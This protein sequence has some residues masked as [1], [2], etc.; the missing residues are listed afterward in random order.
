MGGCHEESVRR[1]C[2]VWEVVGR[3]EGCVCATPLGVKA[4]CEG[5]DCASPLG[6]K[7]KYTCVSCVWPTHQ[8]EGDERERRQHHQVEDV[9]VRPRHLPTQHKQGIRSRHGVI[10]VSSRRVAA[11]GVRCA[12]ARS[13]RVRVQSWCSR[14]I[15]VARWGASHRLLE[16]VDDLRHV[17]AQLEGELLHAAT[18][19]H[20]SATSDPR[21]IGRV[22]YSSRVGLAECRS[23]GELPYY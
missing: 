18:R 16:E 13:C 9:E 10:T 12:C 21:Q 14:G 20:V 17:A 23:S 2:V 22:S 11:A 5:C 6:V 4:R 19:A 8:S 7:A 3:E 15:V 1:L